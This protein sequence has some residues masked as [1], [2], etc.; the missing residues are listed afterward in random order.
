MFKINEEQL[1]SYFSDL[2]IQNSALHNHNTRQ[3]SDYHITYSRTKTRQSSIAIYGAKIW[4]SLD[5]NLISS[6]TLQNKPNTDI[7]ALNIMQIIV[8]LFC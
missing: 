1:P 3:S 4:N 8:F 2:F 7:K 5:K 6:R